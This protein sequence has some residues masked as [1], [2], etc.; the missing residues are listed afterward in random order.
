M[1]RPTKVWTQGRTGD[2]VT[3]IS[4]W[5]GDGRPLLEGGHGG[6][7]GT[8]IL[9]AMAGNPCPALATP[10]LYEGPFIPD[11][12]P[13]VFFGNQSSPRFSITPS[14]LIDRSVPRT[15][16]SLSPV[17]TAISAARS[18]RSDSCSAAIIFGR[19]EPDGSLLAGVEGAATGRPVG[20][21]PSPMG[22][23]ADAVL[24]RAAWKSAAIASRPCLTP[25][26]YAMRIASAAPSAILSR[27]DAARRSTKRLMALSLV[28]AVA[29]AGTLHFIPTP[30]ASHKRQYE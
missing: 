30:R 21:V 29:P 24:E 6:G 5:K 28:N 25:A 17:F 14:S 23:G 9:G 15:V 20:E 11:G 12:G 8:C 16:F 13:S 3:A 7:R 10:K 22:S 1:C 19:T 4:F 26:S 18:P 27:N 2:S